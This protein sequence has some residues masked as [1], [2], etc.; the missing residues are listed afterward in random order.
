[1]LRG[2]AELSLLVLLVAV[3]FGPILAERFGIPGIVGLIFSGTVF[4][5]FVLNWVGADSLVEDLGSIG[6]LYLMFLAGLSFDIRAFF[7]NRRSAVLYGL[8]GFFIPFVLSVWVVSQGESIEAL[9]ALLIGAMWA[10][11]TL[12]AYPEV[13]AAGLQG[14]RGV[15]AAVSAGVVADLLSLTVLA[16]AT[17]TAVIEID[18]I[19]L[20]FGDLPFDERIVE[21]LRPEGVEPTTIDPLLPLWLGLPVLA[22]VCLWIL[23]R[24]ADWFFVRV[25]RVRVERFV[26]SLA[27]MAAG[28]TIALLG[29]M[30][31]LIGAFLVG[32]GM[33]RL[34]PTRGPLMERLEFVGTSLFVPAF[35]VSVGLNIEPAVLVEVETLGLGLLFTGFVVVGKTAAAVIVGLAFRF[36]R[37]EIGV[38]SSLSFGQAASTLAIAQVGENLGMFG[39]NVVN[40]AV[41]AIVLTAL[42]T[43]YG[44]RYFIR[45][46][47]RPA[48]DDLPLGEQLLLDARE[49]GSDLEALVSFTT[50]LARSDGG[51]VI[52]FGIAGAGTDGP[53]TRLAV[54]RTVEAVSATGL[55]ADS[56][57]RVD[58]SFPDGA[59]S[60]VEEREA[61]ALVLSWSGPRRVVDL[62]FGSDIDTIGEQCPVPALAAHLLRPW[63]RVVAPLGRTVTEWDRDDARLVLDVVG[64]L[65]SSSVPMIISTNDPSLIPGSFEVGDVDVR[66]VDSGWPDFDEV[67]PGDLLVLPT[68]AIG[69]PP[70]EGARRTSRLLERTNVVVVGGPHRLSVRPGLGRRPLTGT[71]SGPT[72]P[73]Q[74]VE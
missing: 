71:M 66:I 33:N 65:R 41:L 13:Q 43:S 70:D 9:G 1:M 29:G 10:S 49:T 7:E 69:G 68:H 59:V 53:A 2:T 52:P 21:L 30:E 44:T 4:G 60:L 73:R 15:S 38:M 36:S 37:H 34:V 57:I 17:A 42:L 22:V 45:R 61:S 5:P 20:P 16:F 24:V 46:V 27:M 48:A 63:T 25:G 28:A 39:Q 12:V 35:L 74:E 31:G 18:S 11:N 50:G 58:D 72:P 8:L 62:A 23:P 55:D 40:A 64:R 26:F 47:P 3:V 51:L 56:A 54:A 14:N 32:L 67:Q 6:I 19:E